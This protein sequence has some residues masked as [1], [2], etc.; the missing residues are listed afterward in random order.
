MTFGIVFLNYKGDSD[1][2][3]EDCNHKRPITEAMNELATN[4]H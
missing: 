4:G 2:V 3:V 1:I